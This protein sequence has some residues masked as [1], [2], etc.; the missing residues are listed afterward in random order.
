MRARKVGRRVVNS[1]V[2]MTYITDTT[3]SLISLATHVEVGT[4]E[5][6]STGFQASAGEQT[7]TLRT[8]ADVKVWVSNLIYDN[9]T[10]EEG[11]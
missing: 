4:A 5:K 8:M 6:I 2:R 1:R 10:L 9:P 7:R 11:L 3:Y